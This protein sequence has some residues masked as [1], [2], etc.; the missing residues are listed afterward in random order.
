MKRLLPLLL[1][2]AT[3]AMAQPPPRITP[4]RDVT[5]VYELSGD[6]ASAIPGGVPGNL[7]VQW[8]AGGQR[9][10]AEPQGGKQFL[11][12]D[13]GARSVRL[14]DSAMHASMSL[15]VRRTDLQ[16]LTLEGAHLTRGGDETVA[17]LVCTDFDVHS[18][19]GHGTICE[20]RDGV[21]LRAA[22]ELNGK[23]GGF[24][25]VSVTYG[26]VPDAMFQVP[27]GYLKI[28]IPREARN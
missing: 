12:V 26:P 23:Q 24:T 9:L 2:I 11:L 15:P 10:R 28:E 14:V 8:S 27:R 5:V 4:E 3:P 19:R 18:S 13:L 1:L 25:A 17:G 21:A 20:T 7:Q 16:P 22:G 6:A